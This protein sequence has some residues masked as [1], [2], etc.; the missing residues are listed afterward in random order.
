MGQL[1]L[2][3]EAPIVPGL[4]GS[5]MAES[6]ERILEVAWGQGLGIEREP[7]RKGAGAEPVREMEEGDPGRGLVESQGEDPRG[8]LLVEAEDL[9]DPG[10]DLELLS[11]RVEDR[12]GSDRERGVDHPDPWLGSGEEVPVAI[13]RTEIAQE[14]L[15]RPTH[16]GVPVGLVLAEVEPVALRLDPGIGHMASNRRYT[17]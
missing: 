7:A 2:E 4:L 13:A 11:R 10:P 12:Q 9:L 15:A 14:S 5:E 6:E 1:L 8:L 17:R 3:K 16:L